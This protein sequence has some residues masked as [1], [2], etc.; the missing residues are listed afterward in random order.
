MS[1]N[2]T[3]IKEQTRPNADSMPAK[4]SFRELHLKRNQ[5]PFLY[6]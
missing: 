2:I 3:G 4:P 5:N 1:K 6:E